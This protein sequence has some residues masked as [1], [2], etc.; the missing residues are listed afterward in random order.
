ML[1]TVLGTKSDTQIHTL[2]TTIQR[3]Q[4]QI[5]RDTK[6]D[7]LFV[8]GAA[9]SGL[10]SAV[11][12]RV[13]YLLYRYRGNHTSSQDILFSPNQLF[14]DYISNVLPTT[15][16]QKLV[17]FTYYQYVTRRLPTIQVQLL[18]SQF[19]QQYT[20]VQKLIAR[21]KDCLDFFKTAQTYATSHTRSGLRFRD[22]RFRGTVFFS[23][24]RIREIF[25]SYNTNYTM[26]NRLLATKERHIKML[27]RK[28]TSETKAQWVQTAVQLLSDTTIRSL[29]Q[30]GPKTFKLRH[31]TYRF[32]ARQLVLLGLHAIQQDIVRNRF[33]KLRG[34]YV[35]FLRTVPALYD[36]AATG[37]STAHWQA[38]VDHFIALFKTRKLPLAHATHY[39]HL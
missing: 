9:G 10:T 24:K 2:V 15:P 29:Q 18:F 38:T 14:S 12:Q 31:D 34:Q 7:L 16:T 22:I 27:L 25:Y 37:I 33:I 6:A 39:L 3:T 30:D 1:H 28:I 35:S 17:Q 23:R 19:T 26:G 21:V 8:Q 36:L 5:L 20:P 11:L 4:N 13:A 32:F